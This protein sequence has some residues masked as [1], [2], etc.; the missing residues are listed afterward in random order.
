MRFFYFLIIVVLLIGCDTD[1]KTIEVKV[2]DKEAA[3]EDMS[4]IS[5][6]WVNSNY[7]DCLG[8][9]LPCGCSDGVD[10][11]LIEFNVE[12]PN[13]VNLFESRLEMIDLS[14]KKSDEDNYYAYIHSGAPDAFLS[15]TIIGDTMSVRKQ[16]VTTKFIRYT[17]NESSIN[18]TRLIGRINITMLKKLIHPTGLNIIKE[19]DVS[20]ESLLYCNVELGNI[21]L[22]SQKG[23]C[24]NMWIIEKNEDELL[25]YSY[26][27]SCENKAYPIEISKELIY[28]V[29]LDSRK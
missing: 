6:N 9:D 24:K 13:V 16:G 2:D 17:T 28:T 25:F 20:G 26:L 8:R 29:S 23:N 11:I 7:I 1:V 10:Y 15:F 4:Q 18:G 5:N 19:L 3:V 22:V 27:N 21:N 12:Q 14:V